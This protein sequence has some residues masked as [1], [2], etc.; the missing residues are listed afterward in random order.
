M[1]YHRK[2]LRSVAAE[3]ARHVAV[4]VKIAGQGRMRLADIAER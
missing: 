1:H 4:A 3:Y 2:S